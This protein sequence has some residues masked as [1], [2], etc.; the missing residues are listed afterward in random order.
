MS[1]GLSKDLSRRYIALGYLTPILEY[2][3]SEEL[4]DEVIDVLSK[5]VEK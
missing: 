1:R 5:K 3:N 2:F 4:K